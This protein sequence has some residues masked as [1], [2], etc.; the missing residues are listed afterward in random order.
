MSLVFWTEFVITL[1]LV[2]E[3]KRFGGVCLDDQMQSPRWKQGVLLQIRRQLHLQT[4]VIT[5]KG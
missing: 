3:L 1:K 2:L 5:Q 4:T